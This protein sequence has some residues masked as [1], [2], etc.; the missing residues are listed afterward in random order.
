M[1][2]ESKFRAAKKEFELGLELEEIMEN[3]VAHGSDEWIEAN[4]V[5]QYL[6]ELVGALFQR[7]PYYHSLRKKAKNNE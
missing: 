6:Y 2:P 3:R 5:L 1:I 7:P 4:K